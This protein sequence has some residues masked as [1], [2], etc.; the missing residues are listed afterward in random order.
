VKIPLPILSKGTVD[1][2]TMYMYTNIMI[3]I[4][5]YVS[6]YLRT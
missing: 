6:T 3:Q 4:P 2:N 5:T 1:T